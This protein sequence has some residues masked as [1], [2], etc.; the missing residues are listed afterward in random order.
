[1]IAAMVDPN[2]LVAGKGLSILQQAGIATASGL[3]TTEARDLNPGFI[4]LMER[5]RPYVRVKMAMSLDGRTAM[6]SGVKAC[7]YG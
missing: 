1:M 2:P 4:T 6:A 3:L 7:G 5:K